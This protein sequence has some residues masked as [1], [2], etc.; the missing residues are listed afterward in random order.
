[1]K[2][3]SIRKK[4]GMSQ[5]EFAEYYSIP[6]GTVR[7]WESRDCCPEYILVMLYDLLA[8][9]KAIERVNA[10][11]FTLKYGTKSEIEEMK[12]RLLAGEI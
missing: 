3:T 6:I 12:N 11:E 2:T 5:R 7:N 1:M 9:K 4:L 10:I 8:T